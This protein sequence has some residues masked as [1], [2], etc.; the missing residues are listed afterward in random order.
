MDSTTTRAIKLCQAE[1][2]TAKLRFL[3]QAERPIWSNVAPSMAV[4]P[5]NERPMPA[6]AGS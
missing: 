3:Y 1:L 5:G 4:A 6:P 2:N